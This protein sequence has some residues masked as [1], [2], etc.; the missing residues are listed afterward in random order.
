MYS[1]IWG[2]DGFQRGG[3]TS[4][5]CVFS[6]VVCQIRKRYK[7]KE[8]ASLKLK[9]LLYSCLLITRLPSVSKMLN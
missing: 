7:R 5:G 3:F 1:R 6:A 2:I 9:G 8:A 4:R